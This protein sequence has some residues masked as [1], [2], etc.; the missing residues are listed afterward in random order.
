M[1]RFVA[2]ALVLAACGGG[3]NAVPAGA[4]VGPALT[5]AL[6]AADQA[7]APWRCAAPDG[8]VAAD[9]TIPVGPHT[10]TLT[11]HTL[12]RAGKPA[13]FVIAAIADAGGAAPATL[14]AIARLRTKLT[15][16][17]LVLVLGGMGTTQVELEAT[18]GVLGDH[19]TFPIV[20]LPGDLE[21]VPALTAASTALRSRGVIV[22]DGRLIH[23]IDVPG[24]AIA[25]LGG[26]GARG[27][28]VAADDGCAYRDGDVAAALVALTA[29][30][31]IRILASA[32]A[33]RSLRGGEAGGELAL[34]AGAGQEIDIALH[35][36]TAPGASRSRTGSRTGAAV[37]LTPGTVDA[38]PRLPGPAAPPTAGLLT[39]SGDS[40]TWKP[41]A[42]AE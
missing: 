37:A 40:W 30:P 21:S 32:E 35:G 27:R 24:L 42:D 4:Q 17:D 1:I 33:P 3:S 8:P 6:A 29:R 20:V 41:I 25:T 22:L 13:E 5:A 16:A 31:G 7:R 39:V 38:T 28:L 10:W 26:A 9:S 2:G 36:P 19:P 18:L 14:A 11:G 23:S 34:T 12:S 15:R